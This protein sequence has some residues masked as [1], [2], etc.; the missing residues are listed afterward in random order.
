MKTHPSKAELPVLKP[1]SFAVL[2]ALYSLVPIPALALDSNALP[3]NG[4]VIAGSGTIV[5]NGNVM[6]VHQ[7]SD[8]LIATW[9]TFNIGSGA[10]VN[11]L[12]PGASS[13][14]L[15]RVTGSDGSQ[16][17][18]HL[19]ANGQVFLINPSGVLFGAGSMV[20]VGGLVASSLDISNSDF[21]AGKNVFAGQ[22]K[23][24]V[25]NQGTINAKDGGS[26]AL[27]GSQ[28]L[29][30]GTVVARLGSVVLGGGEKITLDFNGDGLINLE[31]NDPAIGASVVN[32][33]LLSANGGA[34]AMSARDSQAMLS[35]VVNN[36]GVIEARS[37]EQRNG[38][39]I[40]D[41]GSNGV[42][43]N[44]GVLDVSGRNA[45]ERG[46]S[47]T[48][49][50]QYV[51]LFDSG[52]INAD[53]DIGG[54]TVLMGGDYQGGG[55]V[56]EADSTFMG[57]DAHISA[58]ALSS[59][60]GGKVILWSKDSTQFHGG[61]SVSG[62]GSQG[63]GGLVETSGH[64]LEI[65]GIVDLSAVSGQ[66]G[67]WLI[68][69]FNINITKGAS[70]GTST[71]SPFTPN[72]GGS[73]NLSSATLN[74]SLSEGA[75]ILVCT[76]SGAGTSGDI[77][78]LD[79]VKGVGNATLTLQAHRNIVM[80][81]TSIS[82]ADGKTLNVSLYSNFNNSGNGSVALSNATI[83][84]N[85]GNLTISGAVQPD[86]SWASTN[87]SNGTGISLSNGTRL[88]TKGGDVNLRGATSSTL[89]AGST[90][91]AITISNS[92]IDAGGGNISLT[93]LQA[94]STGTGDAFVLT[95]GSKLLTAG[96]GSITVDSTNLGSGNGTRIFST[97]NTIAASGSGNVTLRGSAVSGSGVLV[98]ST[99]ATSA[100]TLSVG[101]GTLTIE[102]N[103]G[104][105]RGVFIASS[106]TGTVTLNAARGGDIFIDGSSDGDAGT[107]LNSTGTGSVINV[108]T[109]SGDITLNGRAGP[110]S[111]AAGLSI[112]SGA[113]GPGN[114]VNILSGSG[115][116]S[117]QGTA[118]GSG[119]GIAFSATN[120]KGYNNVMTGAG[121]NIT[122][123][124]SG[125]G[126]ALSFDHGNNL[127]QVA[128]GLLR[129]DLDTPSANYITHTDD[130]TTLTASGNG[131]VLI[132]R[133]GLIHNG[134]L[135]TA[136][137]P[138][139]QY[140]QAQ[141]VGGAWSQ[142]LAPDYHL[143]AMGSAADEVNI[144][145]VQTR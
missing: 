32:R 114:G 95:G 27:L 22:G 68:D 54:G 4:Q 91:T 76:S 140:Q 132:S 58:N 129:L 28:V 115:D 74:A 136:S 142:P 108:S 18:G 101:D 97:S 94:S 59:G 41:G 1:L 42:V 51:G 134:L 96:A 80:T 123:N 37:L 89:A 90:A 73:S 128:D 19:N 16:I 39:I 77:N 38:R 70:S 133:G 12:Q 78:V 145:V 141:A 127:L 99:A 143:T 25:I 34:V 69:P 84:T 125:G 67:T 3:T 21:M 72:A 83:S 47:V 33:G 23:G 24:A 64:A 49:T 85:G 2:C 62:A 112:R 137:E 130:V 92:T 11:F 71:G 8:K 63:R 124:G 102:G 44:S 31:V 119:A 100:Q 82:A 121:G 109:A 60:D 131:A 107:T 75:K 103:S 57:Q 66:G 56:H 93:A 35:N 79:N 6:T 144:D 86:Q 45:G 116:I 106:G 9:D 40:L 87:V 30:E 13:I 122:L 29:N 14:A 81:N 53:G 110:A 61:I 135:E 36:E 105:G 5:S 43:V 26:V 120:A 138:T 15:N 98:C 139:R 65:T 111:S 48:M 20:D 17:L 88:T 55:N 113:S 52:R 7:G 126:A 117:L 50:G 10:Q 118:Q 104:S 46:G